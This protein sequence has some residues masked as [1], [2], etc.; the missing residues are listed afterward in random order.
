MRERVHVVEYL[1]ISFLSYFPRHEH[2]GGPDAHP[3]STTGERERN[4]SRGHRVRHR[5]ARV[6]EGRGV[7]PGGNASPEAP[8]VPTVEE[9]VRGRFRADPA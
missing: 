1:G 8:G 2:E 3:G 5:G 4:P 9:E 7:N 6:K